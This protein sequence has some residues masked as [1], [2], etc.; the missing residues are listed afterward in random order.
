MVPDAGRRSRLHGVGAHAAEFQ[1]HEAAATQA[2]ALLA[3]PED[4]ARQ[5]LQL[6]LHGRMTTADGAR[7]D[8]LSHHSVSSIVE[9]QG[10]KVGSS[11]SAK[12]DFLVVGGTLADL[13]G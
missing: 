7:T 1:A 5:A 11:V 13:A 3:R 10:G 2:D 12:T 9:D 6:A 8:A 4:A